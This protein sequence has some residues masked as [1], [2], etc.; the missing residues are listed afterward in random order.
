MKKA[1]I[2]LL[3]LAIGSTGIHYSLELASRKSDIWLLGCFGFII[4]VYVIWAS[5][6]Y[7]CKPIRE[8]LMADDSAN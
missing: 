7:V 1:I 4:S 3:G 5:L 6:D 8:K 2:T